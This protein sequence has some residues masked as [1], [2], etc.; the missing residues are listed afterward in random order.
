[1]VKVRTRTAAVM[2]SLALLSGAA[3]C[4]SGDTPKNGPSSLSQAALNDPTA[5]LNQGLQQAKARD[6]DGARKSFQRVIALDK[7][8]KYAWYNLGVIAQTAGSKDEAVKDYDAALAIDPNF[9]SALYN[10]A[11][12]LEPANMDAAI[13]LY[14]KV[15]V[16]NKSASTTYLRLGLLLDHKGDHNG[17]RDNFRQAV[18]LDPTLLNAV[19]QSYRPELP[20]S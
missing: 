3:A 16:I 7:N 19:P 12:V 6:F 1:M 10:K 18:T 5:V 2:A 13:D 17:A 15:L 8:N 9:T 4:T 14:R 11:I 20:G